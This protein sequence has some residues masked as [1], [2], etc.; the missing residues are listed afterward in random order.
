MALSARESWAAVS[1]REVRLAASSEQP[2]AEISR[3]VDVFHG[4]GD[5]GTGQ[6]Q[7]RQIGLH[8]LGLTNHVCQQQFPGRAPGHGDF[9]EI[10]GHALGELAG[11]VQGLLINAPQAIGGLIPLMGADEGDHHRRR[12]QRRQRPEKPAGAT[13]ELCK[14]THGFASFIWRRSDCR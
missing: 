12:R 7:H 1:E 11:F 2:L 5:G 8:S 14:C 4:R 13:A 3:L 6:G 9:V 10:H